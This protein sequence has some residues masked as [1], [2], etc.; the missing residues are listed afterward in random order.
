MTTISSGQSQTISQGQSD[1]GDIILSG[2]T[3]TVD[4]GAVSWKP[5]V[6]GGLLFDSGF[7]ARAQVSAGGTLFDDDFANR[8]TVGSGGVAYVD[9]TGE[10]RRSVIDNGGTVYDGGAANGTI[11]NSGG[12]LYV[13]GPVTISGVTSDFV[14]SATHTVLN[15][16]VEYVVSGTDAHTRIGNGGLEYVGSGGTAIRTTIHQSGELIVSSGGIANGTVIDSGGLELVESGGI[17]SD[18]RIN[19]GGTLEF[20]ASDTGITQ[21]VRFG[22]V[23][24]GVATLKFDA[25]A[26]T[27]AGLIYDGVISGFDLPND[28]IDLVGLGFVSGQTSATSV[29][30]GSNTILTITNGAQTVALTLAG[31][32][33]SD[34]FVVTSD[35][36]GGTI[37]TDPTVP[38]RDSPLGWLEDHVPS[39]VSDLDGFQHGGGFPQ[40]LDQIE[41]WNS[42]TRSGSTPPGDSPNGPWSQPNFPVSGFDAGWQSH[43]VQTMASF[44]DSKGG[45][46]QATPI[47]T[48]D[49]AQQDILAVTS[50]H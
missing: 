17:A 10:A 43:M 39:L 35:G 15:G 49:Q 9:P 29:L 40:L 14:G 20:A 25:T 27:S 38:W 45:P 8:T 28:Q 50:P 42:P 47:Q 44:G 34:S 5:I 11:V 24:G 30:S 22:N 41:N 26:T 36:T 33:T 4:P 31:N 23:G 32:H 12:V 46:S 21:D 37:V 7:V 3:E 16:G 2:G 6:D 1:N 13:G 19:G 18:P 48:N